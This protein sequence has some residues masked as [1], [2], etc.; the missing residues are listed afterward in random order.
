MSK[1][2]KNL[3]RGSVPKQLILFALPFLISNIIQSLYGV[4][5]MIIVGNFAGAASMS[6]VNIG[7]QVTFIITNMVMGLCV[8]GTVLIGQYLGAGDKRALRETIG[9]LFTALLVMAAVLTVVMVWVQEPIL[10]LIQT[11]EESFGEARNYFF[12]TMLGTVFIFGYNALSAV[13]RGMGDSK[14]PLIFVT[15]ACVTNVI[16]DYVLVKVCGMG[17]TGAAVATVASQAVSMILCVL[18]LKKNDFVFDFSLKSFGFHR[19]RLLMLLKIGIPTSIQNVATGTSFLFLTALVNGI[20]FTASAAVGAVGKF[21]GFAIL[22]AVAMSSS[23]SAMSAQNIGAQ[24]IGRARKT[25]VTGMGIAAVISYAI[26]LVVSLIPQVFLEIFVSPDDPAAAEVI[27]YGVDYISAFKF[28]YLIVPFLFCFNG[29]F[30]GAGHTTFSLI[31][32]M[33]SSLLIRIPMSY[34][35]GIVLDYGIIGVGMGAPCASL[36]ALLLGVGFFFSGRWKK[37][38]IIHVRTPEALPEE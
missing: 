35:F 23:V 30:I 5:D 10:R 37:M 27:Q 2:E 24:E 11:P 36:A 9:T 4:V 17:A 12:V 1:F 33:L 25:M 19:E 20:G 28:D 31:N 14:N 18:Y 13:M 6:G 22:P 32:G 3:S 15:V 34:L 29:L 16:L 26:F 38:T 7:S 21:N 8:G